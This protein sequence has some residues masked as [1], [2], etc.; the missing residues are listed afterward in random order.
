M[1]QLVQKGLSHSLVQNLKKPRK[2][3]KKWDTMSQEM[4]LA[5]GTLFSATFAPPREQKNA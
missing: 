2:V 1:T 5:I 3:Y 4:A